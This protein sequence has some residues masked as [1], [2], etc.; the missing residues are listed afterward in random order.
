MTPFT[1]GKV[2]C[3]SLLGFLVALLL[4]TH[5]DDPR[6]RARAPQE[7]RCL[8]RDGAGGVRLRSGPGTSEEQVQRRTQTCETAARSLPAV[9]R[10]RPMLL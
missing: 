10:P 2:L 3:L 5:A 1:L 8:W 4:L 6:P 9:Q 7:P